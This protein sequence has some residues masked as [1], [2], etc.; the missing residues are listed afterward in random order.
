MQPMTELTAGRYIVT[1]ADDAVATYDG[2]LDGFSATAPDTGT[3][4]N[5]QSGESETYGDYLGGRQ[6]AVAA[7]VDA[8][9]DYSYTLAI[10]AFAADLSAKQAVALSAQK[11]VVSI[12]P[13]E[14]RQITATSSTDFLGLSGDNGVWNSIGGA[15]QAGDGVVVGVL[16]TGIAPENPSFA[17][18]AL[19]TSAGPAPYLDGS[20]ITFDKADGGTFTGTCVAGVQFAASDCNTKVVR[21]ELA[22]GVLVVRHGLISS[23]NLV[24]ELWQIRWPILLRD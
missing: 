7:A 8:D 15:D 11:G 5:S 4:L 12:T 13:D 14:L 21:H 18:E 1:L 22:S 20:T 19:G 16:D 24:Q 3:K 9:I 2:G 6:R 17:G 23:P 10:N